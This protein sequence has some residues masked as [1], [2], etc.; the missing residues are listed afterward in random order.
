MT[1]TTPTPTNHSWRKTAAVWLGLAVL[2]LAGYAAWQLDRPEVEAPTNQTGSCSNGGTPPDCQEPQSSVYQYKFVDIDEFFEDYYKDQKV[3]QI[4]AQGRETVIIPSV[5]AA[6]EGQYL[7]EI[8][9]FSPKF[10]MI[11][12]VPDSDAPPQGLYTFDTTTKQFAQM[13]VSSYYQ[14][15]TAKAVS[16]DKRRVAAVIQVKTDT[17]LYVLDLLSDS[18][19]IVAS[20]KSGNETLNYCASGCYADTG[21][22]ISWT[23]NSTVR[24][25]VYDRSKSQED[26]GGFSVHPLIEFRTVSVD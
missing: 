18:A 26:P 5:R 22:D 9:F 7:R 24:Y 20:F 19:K 12:I 13:A 15:Y 25:G 14:G 16:P 1:E 17:E 21:S 4:D 3:L 8:G 10:Y 23:D 6:T 11:S 2:V